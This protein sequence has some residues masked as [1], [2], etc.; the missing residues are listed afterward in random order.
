MTIEKEGYKTATYNVTH[1]MA[2]GGGAGMAGNLLL[3]GVIGAAVDA[4]SGATQRL[5]PNPLTVTLE[6]VEQAKVAVEPAAAAP[7]V[8][9]PQA[10]PVS[11]APVS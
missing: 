7:V 11:E 4:N 1:E 6:P 3:G 9:E 10:E 2:G 8:A 5:V